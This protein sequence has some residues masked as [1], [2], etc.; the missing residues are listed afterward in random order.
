MA[1]NAEHLDMLQKAAEDGISKI[2]KL[3]ERVGAENIALNF[4]V[5]IYQTQEGKQ[6]MLHVNNGLYAESNSLL[7]A[8]E[9]LM[10]QLGFDKKFIRK[11]VHIFLEE[12]LESFKEEINARKD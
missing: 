4:G 10:I 5:V 11:D 3:T 12:K 8:F 9:G 2:N 6:G 1:L 7:G